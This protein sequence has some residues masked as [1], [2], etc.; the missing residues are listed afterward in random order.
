MPEEKQN[1]EGSKKEKTGLFRTLKF[2]MTATY[3][4]LLGITFFGI[5][6]FNDFLLEKNYLKYKRDNLMEV[7]SVID[8]ANQ[9]D[10]FGEDEFENEILRLCNNYNVNFVVTDASSNT[11]YS[12]IKDPGQISR[13]LRDIVFARDNIEKKMIEETDEYSLCYLPDPATG[14]EYAVLWGNLD[15]DRFFMI[16]TA[17][18]SIRESAR[19]ANK[20]L[21][22]IGAVAFVIAGVIIW[23]VTNRVTRPIMR[24]VDVSKRMSD[25]DFEARYTGCC[26]NEVDLLGDNM[27][28]MA[29]SLEDNISRLKTANL[30]LQRDV[31][32]RMHTDERRKEFLANVSH[33]LKTPI[34]LIQGYAEGLKDGIIEDQESRDYYC[35]VIM[36]ETKKMNHLVKFLIS[37]NQV[38]SGEDVM[39]IERF[40]LDA[41]ISASVNSFAQMCEQKEIKMIY[42]PQPGLFV[43]GDE[44]QV[45]EVLRN[46]ISNAVHHCSGRKEIIIKVVRTEDKIRTCVFN[47]G[48]AI[49]EESL[50][51]LWEK[52]YKVDK[53]R[54]RE[55]GG[56]GLGLSIVKAIMESLHQQYGVR[57]YDD[58]VEFYFE[59]STK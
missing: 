48:E 53:A 11:I 23:V 18:E 8:S 56:S 58:G 13:Q 3:L 52:F 22:C 9:E 51:R 14:T 40:D 17:L 29:D 41:L 31:E 15:D 35:D 43:W 2:Q 5:W 1:K 25:M 45:E 30:E 10:S 46:Y 57:N 26:G 27:N 16:R 6:F 28:R 4:I 54:T 12:N 21:L 55:Y 24:L 38:E 20:M 37:L 42:T 47:S 44:Y 19:I 34:A 59:L 36:D 49:P 39:V 33:E 7:Y 32:A 50:S